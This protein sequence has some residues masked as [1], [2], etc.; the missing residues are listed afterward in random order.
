MESAK[1]FGFVCFSSPDEATKVRFAVVPCQV[2]AP[3]FN[4]VHWAGCD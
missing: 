1:G 2:L 4:S 3:L